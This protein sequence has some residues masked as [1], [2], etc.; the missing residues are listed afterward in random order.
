MNFLPT[1]ALHLDIL[2][3]AS[4]STL[5]KNIAVTQLKLSTPYKFNNSTSRFQNIMPP[6]S[7]LSP[8]ITTIIIFNCRILQQNNFNADGIMQMNNIMQKD[9]TI[10]LMTVV[11]V[12]MLEV[13]FTSRFIGTHVR[14]YKYSMRLYAVF[15][16]TMI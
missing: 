10:D 12:L 4:A 14:I 6:T 3:T 2:R 15:M 5:P 16:K 9:G 7:A 11:V 1:Y 13:K 8:Q